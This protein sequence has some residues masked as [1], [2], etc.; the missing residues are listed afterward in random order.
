MTTRN[1][2]MLVEAELEQLL[3]TNPQN[4]RMNAEPQD[5]V[6]RSHSVTMTP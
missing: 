1:M 2:D 4:S 5:H 6:A 3:G